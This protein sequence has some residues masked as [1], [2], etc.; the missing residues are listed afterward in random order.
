MKRLI[1][2]VSL[3]AMIILAYASGRIKYSINENWHFYAGDLPQAITD[4]CDTSQW[5]VVDLPHTWNNED[6]DDEIPGY[7]R[8][9]S[10]YRRTLHIP[11]SQHNNNITIYFE[12]AN[13]TAEVYINGIS[14]GKH[15]GGYTRF[16]F[17]ITPYVKWGENNTIAIK[18]DNS[19]DADIPPLSADFTF[20]GGIYRDVYLIY[21]QPVHID[22]LDFASDG[23]YIRTPL[24]DSRQATVEI[25]TV[26]TNRS[27]KKQ[28]LRIEH[29][30]YDAEGRQVKQVSSIFKIGENQD[31]TD[32]QKGIKIDNPHLWDIDDPYCYHVETRIY[33]AKSNKCLDNVSSSFGLRWFSFDPETGFSLN[34]RSRKL[35]GTNRHQ[36]YLK[37]G[38]ALTDDMHIRD[39]KLLKEMGGNFLRISHYPQDPTI[40]EMCDRLGI[41]TS[42]EIP[43]I[44]RVTDTPEFE[45]NC[46]NMQREMIRQN[47]N[48]P[49]VMIW[50]YMNEITLDRSTE[51]SK[52]DSYFG[53][54]E[55]IARSLEEITRSE[56]SSRYTMVACHNGAEL[57]EKAKIT[58]IPMIL[59]WN[60]YQGWYEPDINEFQRLTDSFHQKYPEKVLMITEYGP[61]VDPR[62][63]AEKCQRFDFS[64]DYGII[65]HKHYLREI[66]ERPYIAGS[67]MWNLNDFYSEVRTD[68][69][70]HVNNKGVT[71]LN[72]EKKDT[73]L[74]YQAAWNKDGCILIG[75]REW[76]NRSGI[77]DKDNG[78]QATQ[79]VPVFSNLK[80]VTMTVNEKI[81]GTRKVTDGVVYFDVPFTNGKNL[82]E[83]SGY[84]CENR[85]V[86]DYA[87][88]EFTL[89]PYETGDGNFTSLHMSLGSHMY[90]ED[91]QNG[92]TWLP[93]Q[94]Y[95]PGSWGYTG[96]EI[97]QR[98]S[99]NGSIIG[100][101]ADIL[102]TDIDPIFQTQRTGIESFKADVP[103]GQ[104][105]ICFFW[106]ELDHNFKNANIVYNLG[107]S[108][109]ENSYSQR[110]FNVEINGCVQLENIDLAG[111]YGFCRSVVKK[112]VVDVSDGNGIVIS[113]TPVKGAAVLNAI[114]IYRNH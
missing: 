34:G 43:V 4:S 95:S 93:E 41:V 17:D 89:I 31:R 13:Q 114:A 51:E 85:K 12:G 69:V 2:T 15:T 35:Y 25:E 21:T 99:W 83:A 47:Y 71:G 64:Q 102:H 49:S 19:Y 18:V 108:T 70:P 113:F 26:I 61:G 8:G 97:Y 5:E 46:C 73:Y 90:F 110:I 29:S 68:A 75:Q 82:L 37:M 54:V 30:I 105:S 92:I 63:H 10:W 36:D 57:Y 77:A 104:Y 88:C 48:H 94:A 103:D 3:T 84:D 74:F 62:L 55:R 101:D 40:L 66:M 24:V 67:S 7:R 42:V 60:M 50:A 87:T 59:G 1:L 39:I 100:T 79:R 9:V 53:V 91:R 109:A 56:D 11:E 14:A 20:F 107:N 33:D 45:Q 96:G 106:A 23:I 112:C 80:E 78:K 38:N 6:C 81:I 28:N 58:E 98:K 72:R 22:L 86:T 65:Y 52:K 27:D 32:I 111:E 44:N 76:K 16:A